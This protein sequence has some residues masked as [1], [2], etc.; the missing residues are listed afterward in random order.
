MHQVGDLVIYVGQSGYLPKGRSY[1]VTGSN[2]Q[3][4]TAAGLPV[5]QNDAN[6]KPAAKVGDWVRLNLYSVTYL[7]EEVQGPKLKCKGW[8]TPLDF[9]KVTKVTEH[10]HWD[11]MQKWAAGAK[12]EFRENPADKW[13]PG[14]KLGWYDWMEY[15]VAPEETYSNWTPHKTKPEEIKVGD[16]CMHSGQPVHIVA[17]DATHATTRCRQYPKRAYLTK[18]TTHKHWDLM[19]K[20]AA[21]A[22]IEFKNSSGAWYER[23][24]PAW[25]VGTQYRVKPEEIKAGD[26]VTYGCQVY[27]VQKASAKELNLVGV[28]SSVLAS[29]CTKLTTHK[30]W[31]VMQKY[32]KGEP[33]QYRPCPYNTWSDFFHKDDSNTRLEWHV[34]NEY[35]TASDIRVGD[36]VVI[37]PNIDPWYVKSV[38]QERA[39]LKYRGEVELSQLQRLYEH[40]HMA[41]MDEWAK[42]AEVQYRSSNSASWIGAPCPIWDKHTSYRIKPAEIK[43]GDWVTYGCQVYLV[44]EVLYKELDLKGVDFPVLTSKCV[45]LTTHKH[46]DVMQ[47]YA[48][49]EPVQ[50]RSPKHWDVMQKYAKGEP[51][52]YWSPSERGWTDFF[53]KADHCMHLGWYPE[54]EYRTASNSIKVGDWVIIPPSIEPFYVTDV[55]Q[56]SADLKYKGEV[57]LSKLQKLHDH[58]HMA[59]MNEW[60]KG[61]EVQ[62][63]STSTNVWI[64]TPS[65]IWDEHTYYRVR[66]AASLKVGDWFY[67]DGMPAYI[68]SMT[69][70]T[71]K[72]KERGEHSLDVLEGKIK[73]T[74]H[75]HM[76]VMREWAK[77][78]EVEYANNSKH[79]HTSS[80][81]YWS[82]NNQYR[83]KPKLQEFTVNVIFKPS[84][85]ANATFK[86]GSLRIVLD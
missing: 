73:L 81:P 34:S 8:V 53:S 12:I 20:W 13:V 75:P 39:V 22:K 67:F 85:D 43:A 83:V 2:S 63:R 70:S 84:P 32:A 58:P 50:Y 72:L 16:W 82:T 10:V 54:Y 5:H 48:K 49:G 51:V 47:K 15:R 28:H 14:F 65:P 30:H 19:Q 23:E 33:V 6:W 21:G 9:H 18:I 64:D 38:S 68:E 57:E 62:Y 3:F 31:D 78:A 60:A 42:G 79:W 45:K 36:W 1:L 69:S 35:R 25:N 86:A 44:K 56:D 71:C 74:R 52:Q 59:V 46:W 40:P 77:G 55:I 37:S 4:F 61:A 7:V 11:V 41:V 29:Q 17:L 76:A 27:L 66:P 26:W 80:G 24:T